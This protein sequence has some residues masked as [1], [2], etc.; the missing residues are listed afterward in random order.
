MIRA[1]AAD[2]LARARMLAGRAVADGFFVGASRLA[3]LHP[4][5]A[6]AAHRIEHIVDIPYEASGSRDHLLDVWR[7][8]DRPVPMPVVLYVHGGGF[9]ILSKDTHWVMALR[10]LAGTAPAP[11]TED[12]A[13]AA[14]TTSRHASPGRSNAIGEERAR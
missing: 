14:E 11:Q 3:R 13:R 7:P 9:R 6:P 2:V 8:M 1:R 10:A 5:A 12:S 4:R